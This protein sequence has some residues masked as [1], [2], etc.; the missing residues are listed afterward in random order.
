VVSSRR[1]GRSKFTLALLILTSITL[2]TLD[3]RGFGPL[4]TA[5]SSVLGVFSPVG[6]FFGGVFEPVGDAWSGAFDQRDLAKENEDLR[7]QI[8]DLEGQLT[9]GEVAKEANRQLLEQVGIEYLGDVQ[10]V[11][12]R[13]VGGSIN[14]FDTTI[15]ID[16]GESSGI[17][18]DMPVVTGKGL[19][20]RIAQTSASSA[21]VELLTSGDF[22]VGFT[23]VGTA[24][25]GVL[26]GASDSGALRGTVDVAGNVNPGQLLI[27]SGTL[28]SPYPQGI[29]IGMVSAVSDQPST[30]ERT[31]EIQ[32]AADVSDLAY[33]TVVLWQPPAL[34]G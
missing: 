23:A 28:G 20:G 24:A 25:Q 19:I 3:F 10:T 18:V 5:R 6:D 22:S 21:T 30:L 27:T 15:L 9:S 33:V 34:G 2:L 8:D 31:L 16:K 29:P 4:Q 7:R 32:M 26:S 17:Q 14:N 11:Q 1:S 12:A 13:V